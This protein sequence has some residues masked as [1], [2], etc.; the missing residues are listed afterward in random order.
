MTYRFSDFE[1]DHILLM[2]QK[3]H[4]FFDPVSRSSMAKL[5]QQLG[6][7]H[8]VTTL[9]Q[10]KTL[11]TLL[12]ADPNRMNHSEEQ[13]G[14]LEETPSEIKLAEMEQESEIDPTLILRIIEQLR[15]FIA[16]ICSENVE[17]SNYLERGR[18]E[19]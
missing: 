18:N 19:K 8:T 3:Y 13:R 10:A 5:I 14:W 4:G 17:Q 9:D 11:V 16:R 6:T 2:Y 15:I 1:W 7:S 12:S